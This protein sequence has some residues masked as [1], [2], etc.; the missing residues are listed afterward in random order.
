[1]IATVRDVNRQLSKMT[2]LCIAERA[3]QEGA[4]GS[5]TAQLVASL[6]H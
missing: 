1:L 5:K 4:F 6:S 3:L 2:T